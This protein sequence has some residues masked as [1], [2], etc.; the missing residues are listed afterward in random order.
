[1]G[2]NDTYNSLSL[3]FTLSSQ[4]YPTLIYFNICSEV[5]QGIWVMQE[6][7]LSVRQ[8]ESPIQNKFNTL[9]FKSMKFQI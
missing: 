5:E 1:M 2:P 3:W 8:W 7:A 4:T 9:T 6:G